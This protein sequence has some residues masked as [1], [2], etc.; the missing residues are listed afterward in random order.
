MS[1]EGQGIALPRQYALARHFSIASLVCTVIVAV[2]LGWSYQHLALRDLKHLAEDRN[3]A[4]THA[5]S[6]SLWPK[7]SGLMAASANTSPHALRAM[8]YRDSLYTLVARQMKDT[9]VVKVKI[10]A[11]DGVTVFSSDP[12]QTGE[13][14]S[15]NS[16]FLA[17]RNGQVISG[18][19]HRHSFDAFEGTRNHLDIFSTYLPI[20]DE[21][22][23][24][25]AVFEI[26]SDVTDLTSQLGETRTIVIA[27]VLGLLALLYALQYVF[28]AR[29]QRTIDGQQMLLKQSIQDLDQ[30]VQERTASLDATN[31]SL[32]KE[33][34]ERKLVE[35]IL[36]ESTAR[37]QAVTQSANDAIVTADSRG[38]IVGWNRQAEAAFG[39]TEAEIISQ[40]LTRLIPERHRESHVRGIDRVLAGG[41]SR[42]SG[43]AFE[44]EGLRRD[45]TE[46]PIELSLAKWEVGDK[47]YVSGTIR[48]ISERMRTEQHLRVAAT[49][50]EA[51]EGVTI[52]DAN[53]V[54]L[55]V[56]RAFT[57]ITGY[58]S[59]EAVGNTP[60]MLSS[61]R[62]DLAYYESMWD[63]LAR[64]GSWQGE[65][66]N[67][68]K[69]GE[70]FPEWLSITAVRGIGGE[71]TNYVGTFADITERK[72]AEN[73]I[74]QLAFYDHL[75]G[76]PNRRLLLDRLRHALAGCVRNS[77]CGALMFFD[78]DN[79]KTLNDT[80]GH[81]VGDQLLVEVASR[82]Q[83]CVRQSDTVAR[84]GGDEFVVVLEDLD[85]GDGDQL[86]AMQAE[87][88]AVKIQAVLSQPYLLDIVASGEARG[89]RS[90]HCSSSIGITLFDRTPITAEELMKRAD[91]AMYQAKAAGRNTLRF[92]DP[93]M[94]AV[95]TARATLTA[96]LRAAIRDDQFLVHYQPQFDGEGCITG[97]EALVRWQHPRRGL[98]YPAEFIQQA[99][100]TRLIMP[101]GHWVLET[102]CRQLVVWAGQGGTAHLSL[103][104]NVSSRQFHQANFVD[105]VL[106]VL[107]RTGANPRR[108]K[109]EVTESLLLHDI[110][111]IV[112]KMSELKSAGV[113]FSLDDFG[114]GY[115][116]L[117]YLKRLPLDQ[118]KIDQSFVRDVLTDGNDAAIARTIIA[119]GRSLGLA[120]IAEGVETEAQ[121][122]FLAAEGCD[123][124]QG[125]LFGKPGTVENL[126]A[127]RTVEV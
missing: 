28:V 24:I 119:L 58:E 82:L 89:K 31:L 46:F 74:A 76:L 115:S 38:N 72:A 42:V 47:R 93:D 16:A 80:L 127:G 25:I 26:Y 105:Q 8:A 43:K 35:H 12:T 123:A 109:L 88:L 124:Y 92:F 78:L 14:K 90:H 65:I 87:A 122:E 54:I 29:A 106:A 34:E 27:T 81:D 94:Q 9:E 52:T 66:W 45:G 113:S 69:N 41:E 33:I 73:E 10:Y 103:A 51:Q 4:L 116:S 95:V 64:T 79:F 120:V 100:A 108:L 62:H 59:D 83:S 98:V 1:Q 61:G 32:L 85:G 7:F 60:H 99:E 114:T 68:R 56:N 22:K 20:R 39:Y 63:S 2:L 6:N 3:L 86:A 55:R 96:D 75:T 126:F 102:A 44:T 91:T 11:L 57:E 37:Y 118:L 77:R 111:D 13:N 104:V 30:R 125:N 97:A 121:F 107:S 67:R 15:D 101:L 23:R 48:D 21:Q 5:L 71:V 50:F 117:S 53:K 112:T 49:T 18:L 36:R 84:L 19:T 110:E 40:P 70:E 17:A